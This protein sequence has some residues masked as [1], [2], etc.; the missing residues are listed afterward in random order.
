MPIFSEQS[1]KDLMDKLLVVHPTREN[2]FTGVGYDL[3]I[4]FYI[5]INKKFKKVVDISEVRDNDRGIIQ[6]G[7][8]NNLIVITREYVY[9]S[10]R[11]AA[12][13]HSKSTLAAQ[14]IFLNS[15]TGDPNWDGRLIFSLYNAA[16]TTVGIRK[17]ESIVTMVV[18]NVERRSIL[19]PQDSRG[20]LDKYVEG[21]GASVAPA[22]HYVLKKDTEYSQRVERT[23]RFATHHTPVFLILMLFNRYIIPRKRIWVKTIVLIFLCFSVYL[24]TNPRWIQDLGLTDKNIKNIGIIG[25]ICSIGSLVYSFISDWKLHSQKKG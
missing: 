16:G 15:T 18:Y 13:F 19:R 24:L 20:V 6:L 23:A 9:L 11:V 2:C 8:K 10:C 1:F 4:G 12:T 21:F 17:D 7:P 3:N 25:S 14:A 5:Q 22:V